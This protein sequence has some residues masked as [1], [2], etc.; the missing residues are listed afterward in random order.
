MDRVVLISGASKGMGLLMAQRLHARGY[1]V[2]G[3]SRN[4]E[5]GALPFPLLALDVGDPASV[6]AVVAQVQQQAGRLDVLINNAGYDLYG[7][8][9]ET[10]MEE[11]AAQIDT[12]FFGAVRLTKAA[13]PL[14]RRRPGSQI[15]NLSSVGGFV[16][17][18]YNS[19]YAASKYALEG[20]SESLRY[21]LLADQIYVSL[22]QPGQV[23][24]DTLDTSIRAAGQSQQARRAAERARAMGRQ[25]RLLPEAVVDVVVRVIES[26]RPQLRYPVGL[27]ASLLAWLKPLLPDRVRESIMIGQFMPPA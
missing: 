8:A 14:L 5:Q 10:S 6:S 9:E 2:F 25:A 13:L 24:T 20:Y 16:S 17:L 15:I 26:P 21:E 4:P 11:L 19:A 12:N 22:I 1:R 18:P 23:R 27:Q 7:A 3:T